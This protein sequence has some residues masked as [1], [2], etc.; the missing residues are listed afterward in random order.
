MFN[1]GGNFAFLSNEAKS[2][3]TFEVKVLKK[4]S[5]TKSV[6]VTGF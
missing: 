2:S 3:K 1:R 5:R 4:T 6:K